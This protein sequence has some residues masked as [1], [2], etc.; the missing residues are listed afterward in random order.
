MKKKK[1]GE[2]KK[3]GGIKKRGDGVGDVGREDRARKGSDGR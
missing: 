1:Y 2:M 3:Q